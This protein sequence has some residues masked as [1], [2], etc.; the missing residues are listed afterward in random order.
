MEDPQ[1]Q[2]ARIQEY[3]DMVELTGFENHYPYQLSGGMQ[4]RAELARAM[5]V[6]PETLIMDEPFTGL[7][8]LTHMKMR[9]EVV[10]MHEFLGKTVI[11]VTH[12]I[13]DAL[14]MGDRVV[15]LG[16]NPSGV[17]LERKLEMPHPRNIEKDPVLSELRDE[18]Y[19]MMGVSY[20]V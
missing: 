20:V 13:D 10:N 1:A 14:V 15:I 4:R 2:T 18:I 3:I 17:K 9:E 5:V 8:F 11:M 7:D 16:G 19:F 12:F 6:N